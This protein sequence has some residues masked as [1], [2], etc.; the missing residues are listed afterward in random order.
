[1][2]IVSL[3]TDF[4]LKDYFVA[5]IKAELHQEIKDAHIVDISHQVSPFNHTEAAYILTNA[6]KAFPKGSIHIVG[7]DSEFSPENS[8]IVMLFDGHFFIGANNGILSLIKDD[9]VPDK[10]VEIN[11][12]NNIT[13]SFP[14]LDVFVKV[15]GHISRK[16]SL[17]V[18]GK[19]ITEIKEV[20]GVRP[21]INPAE[22]KILG[23]VIY[24]D[25]FGNVVTNITEKL[26]NE[27]RK[28]RAFTI[29]AKSIKFNSIHTSYTEAINFNVPKENR[30]QDGK[31]IAL[32]NAAGHLELSI[33]KSN[34]QTVGSAQSLFGL[35]FRDTVTI[36]FN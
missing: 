36:K 11:I 1:M 27:Y 9:R 33:Y 7:V 19:S 2:S 24:I 6:Y 22:D 16:G 18:I 8:H 29:F 21:V 12:H 3:I 5:A 20:T 35:E 32:F 4:G 30:D 23:S 31:K 26:F 15:A 14:V 25:N 17:D 10:L 34:P 28:G 13:S